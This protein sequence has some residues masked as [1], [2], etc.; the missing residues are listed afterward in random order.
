M[1]RDLQVS[2][3]A[4]NEN[5]LESFWPNTFLTPSKG[6][7]KCSRVV[8][9]ASSLD[10]NS[11]SDD[12]K[13][14]DGDVSTFIRPIKKI[15]AIAPRNMRS[16]TSSTTAS[17]GNG[18]KT[19]SESVNS[20]YP[21]E[22]SEAHEIKLKNF[23]MDSE[24]KNFNPANWRRTRK[25]Q[26]VADIQCSEKVL[27]EEHKVKPPNVVLSCVLSPIM[28]CKTTSHD[29][30]MDHSEEME[31]CPLDLSICE[32][33]YIIPV[34]ASSSS[35]HHQSQQLPHEHLSYQPASKE[36]DTCRGNFNSSVPTSQ[37][38]L[39]A[40][41]ICNSSA[42][43]G[44]NDDIILSSSPP[45]LLP[46]TKEFEQERD[47]DEKSS[48][49]RKR[50]SFAGNSGPEKRSKEYNSEQ[51]RMMITSKVQEDKAVVLTLKGNNYTRLNVLGKGGSSCVYRVMSQNDFQL[52]AYK[53]VDVKGST[54]D[55]EAVF[56]SYI[57]E[58]ELLKRLQGSSPY[59]IDLIDAEVNREEMYIA[60]VMEAG[61]VD[62]AK[63]LSQK[64]Q[65]AATAH[66]VPSSH[67]L[68]Q[69]H[70]KPLSSSASSSSSHLLT[71]AAAASTMRTAYPETESSIQLEERENDC[72]NKELLNPFFTRLVWQEMLEAVDHIH[73]H[74][75]VHGS[76][77]CFYKHGL[78]FFFFHVG[79]ISHV[80][81]L[82]LF[83]SA[84]PY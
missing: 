21:T 54:E 74:R 53:R 23:I 63:V 83:H 35:R 79:S 6:L 72:K 84:L 48:H 61:D 65:Q 52:Y 41:R 16:T 43:I 47:N 62:L 32:T 59:I 7:G 8:L 55:N 81:S 25:T 51:P 27:N 1:R 77:T 40:V 68:E 29:S 14:N 44:S 33:K 58:I 18:N 26:K 71:T 80:F 13:G 42:N 69:H 38:A 67:P 20:I 73:R 24:M 45:L 3:F 76:Y 10:V 31:T 22:A 11:D 70:H 66:P 78:S 28:D 64:Q 60:I 56:D 75:I 82:V 19:L 9:K 34:V 15:N 30:I 49:R 2:M 37:D 50:V 57:N 5:Y 4:L 12:D 46:H 39:I 36:E 17:V